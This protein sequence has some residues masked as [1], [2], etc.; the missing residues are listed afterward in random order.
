MAP[1]LSENLLRRLSVAETDIV[2]AGSRGRPVF[3][4]EASASFGSSRVSATVVRH[5]RRA[6]ATALI[7]LIYHRHNCAK[8]N[9]RSTIAECDDIAV[10]TE[11]DRQAISDPRTE[12]RMVRVDSDCIMNEQ[13]SNSRVLTRFLPYCST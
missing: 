2:P 11:T 9:I 12:C 10:R 6:E 13:S 4:G 8:T 3:L 5:L 7:L 1:V